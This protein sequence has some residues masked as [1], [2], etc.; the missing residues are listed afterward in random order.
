M[1]KFMITGALL[2]FVIGGS[3]GVSAGILGILMR[4]WWG[5]WRRSL[6]EA[7]MKR[8]NAMSEAMSKLPTEVERVVN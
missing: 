7:Q 8:I 6:H 5:V 3:S 1:R 2:G 4:W